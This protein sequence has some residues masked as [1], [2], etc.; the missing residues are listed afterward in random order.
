MFSAKQA[1]M[2]MSSVEMF[3]ILRYFVNVG[4]DIIDEVV[5][6]FNPLRAERRLPASSQ[7]DHMSIGAPFEW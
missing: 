1:G 7:H 3:M 5:S 6:F 2:N 4:V